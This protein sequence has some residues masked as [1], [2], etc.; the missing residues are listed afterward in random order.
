MN[1]TKKRGGKGFFPLAFTAKRQ[2]G[3]TPTNEG[4]K[5]VY[6]MLGKGPGCAV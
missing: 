2:Q 1:K 4:E 5:P 6:K 3:A